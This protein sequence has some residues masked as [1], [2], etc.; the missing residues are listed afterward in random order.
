MKKK[1]FIY[2]RIWYHNSCCHHKYSSN[3]DSNYR[4]EQDKKILNS[5]KNMK[6]SKFAP[7]LLPIF[8]IHGSESKRINYQIIEANDSTGSVTFKVIGPEEAIKFFPDKY[9]ICIKFATAKDDL[10]ALI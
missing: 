5:V 9:Q 6:A 1:D 10:D 8:L 4:L 3:I 2:F 7:E